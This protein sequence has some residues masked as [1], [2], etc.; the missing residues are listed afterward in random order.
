M[1]PARDSGEENASWKAMI[2]FAD[3]ESLSDQEWRDLSA[4][5]LIDRTHLMFE[6]GNCHGRDLRRNVRIMSDSTNLSRGN[7]K[8]HLT[9]E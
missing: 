3:G 2:K 7:R 6:L 1:K 4:V 5:T 9:N 8:S